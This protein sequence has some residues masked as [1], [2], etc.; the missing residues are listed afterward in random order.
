MSN[1]LHGPAY[2]VELW[3]APDKQEL[4]KARL[5]AEE[6]WKALLRNRTLKEWPTPD[7]YLF[8][9]YGADS[10]ERIV[11]IRVLDTSHGVLS[12]AMSPNGLLHSGQWVNYEG[13]QTFAELISDPQ[14]LVPA[15]LDD[16]TGIHEVRPYYPHP[17]PPVNPANTVGAY[18]ASKQTP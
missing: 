7:R 16:F 9:Q 13:D 17:E 3:T 14:T 15:P 18:R 5:L 6:G 11:A 12:S 2:P 4:R 1:R 10:D 8:A